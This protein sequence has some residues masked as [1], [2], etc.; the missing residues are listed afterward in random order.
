MASHRWVWWLLAVVGVTALVIGIVM[1][2]VGLAKADQV[3]SVVGSIAGLLGLGLAGAALVLAIRA[4]RRAS[5]PTPSAAPA[6]GSSN[7]VSNSTIQGPNIQI[8]HAGG[9]VSI[10]R[11]K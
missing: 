3:G 5:S 8:G 11:D 4:D 7:S 2:R 9:D 6:P 1:L 10:E